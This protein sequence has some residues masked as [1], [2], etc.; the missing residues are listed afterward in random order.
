MNFDVDGYVVEKC[1]TVEELKALRD[2]YRPRSS[3]GMISD[4][5]LED[6]DIRAIARNLPLAS[7]FGEDYLIVPYSWVCFGRYL[8]F[9]TDT[10]VF[11]TVGFH[12]SPF[13]KMATVVVHLQQHPI[14]GLDV[15]PGSHKL[16]DP[17]VELRRRARII[18]KSW[19][20]R[21]IRKFTPFMNISFRDH[22][23]SITPTVKLGE[24]VIFNMKLIHASN[25]DHLEGEKI[26]LFF[27]VGTNSAP[28]RAYFKHIK[29][30]NE[31]LREP[32]RAEAVKKLNSDE[33]RFL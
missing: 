20:R 31:Y 28:T 22:P 8:Q 30:T 1:A 16:P 13:F 25:T 27:R 19:I 29:S 2:R 33:V 7:I 18:N 26:M 32:S 11:D 3:E 17:Y 5:M 6:E 9:H 10:T 23:D 15:V 14:G 4:V 12:R 24:A 21:A